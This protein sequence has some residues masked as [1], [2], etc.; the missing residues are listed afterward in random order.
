MTQSTWELVRAPI[1]VPHVIVVALKTV[2][3]VLAVI[4]LWVLIAQAVQSG[5]PLGPGMPG[6]GLDL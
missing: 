1:V 2:A 6:P 3:V 4:G 5:A